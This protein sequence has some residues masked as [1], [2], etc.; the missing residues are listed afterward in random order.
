MS[1]LLA[2]DSYDDIQKKKQ[3]AD[4]YKQSTTGTVNLPKSV[5]YDDMRQRV[6]DALG[7]KTSPLDTKNLFNDIDDAAIERSIPV[8]EA[9]IETNK[10][11]GLD[12][13]RYPYLKDGLTLFYAA[14]EV[15]NSS[16][17]Q[18]AKKAA[19]MPEV[20]KPIYTIDISSDGQSGSLRDAVTNSLKLEKLPYRGDI[21]LKPEKAL[22]SEVQK[23]KDDT[24]ASDSPDKASNTTGAKRGIRFMAESRKA[25][26]K[27]DDNMP[28]KKDFFSDFQNKNKDKSNEG[29]QDLYSLGKLKGKE[30]N[31]ILNV[32]ESNNNE[33]EVNRIVDEKGVTEEHAK[34]M[35]YA[36]KWKDIPEYNWTMKDAVEYAVSSIQGKANENIHP[37]KI[38]FIE[39]YSDVVKD[40][41]EKYDIPPKLLAGVMYVEFGG[42]PML[43]DQLAYLGRS[44]Y[45]DLPDD[46]KKRI[47]FGKKQLSVS[48]DKTSFGNTSIQVRR[49]KEML[50]YESD[51]NK[52][53]EIIESL[54]NPIQNIYMAACHLNV[55][56]NVDYKG[57]SA[58]ELTDDEIK[59]IATRYNVGPE[60]PKEKLQSTGYAERIYENIDDILTA[61]NG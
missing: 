45:K 30:K 57:K 22:F 23:V 33:K 8:A 4:S 29:K 58:K 46:V 55:L 47:P 39:N 32:T 42:D 40:A 5:E 50:G 52:Q 59:T 3:K 37:K 61:L 56:R 48:P 18:K 35:H 44:V 14:G 25:E 54:N 51:T 2:I 1:K 38:D 53:K 15:G 36:E 43:N 31:E 10:N 6:R 49:A 16:E 28:E 21:N 11:S 17:M 12:V 41:A 26:D 20:N 24:D 19:Y 27:I 7:T 34:I 60:V 9:T 13:S